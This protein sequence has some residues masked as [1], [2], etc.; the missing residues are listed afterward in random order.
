MILS[1]NASGSSLPIMIGRSGAVLALAL[2]LVSAVASPTPPMPSPGPAPAR[3]VADVTSAKPKQPGGPAEVTDQRTDSSSTYRSPNGSRIVV[4]SAGPIR[5]SRSGHWVPTN[6][7]LRRDADGGIRPVAAPYTTWLS[8]GGNTADAAAV[9]GPTGLNTALAW[10][11]RLPAP[12]LSGNRALYHNARPGA[13]LL[14]EVTRTGFVA[15]LLPT[16]QASSADS[17]TPAAL[18]PPLT[19][20]NTTP[21]ALGQLLPRLSTIATTAAP[22]GTLADTPVA[23]RVVASV[24]HRLSPPLGTT[25]Q[26]T[27]PGGDLSGD[28]NLRIGGLDGSTVSRGF[29][30]WD[31]SKLRGQKVSRATLRLY[32]EWAPT[33]QPQGWQVWSS[34]PVGPTTR[35]ANQPAGQRLWASSTA[36]KGYG[37]NCKAGWTNV[38]LTQ[39]VQSWVRSG[40]SSGTIMLRAADERNPL[41]WKRFAS[42]QGPNVPALG[43]TLAP[44]GAS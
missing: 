25:V 31:L 43:V 6:L 35:W 20:R 26:N 34:G 17:L 12:Q 8:G 27:A 30:T 19:L 23:D 39:L 4:L 2:S 44:S 1:R 7:T 3:P 33:C 13:D 40:A 15:A 28:P 37:A 14:V 9:R 21:G 41:G 36:T 16:G 18:G 32:A 10:G 38:D 29:L 11:A 22:A 42:G 24:I 5:T